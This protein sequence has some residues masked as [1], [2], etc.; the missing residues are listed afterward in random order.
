MS[1]RRR[2]PTGLPTKLRCERGLEPH[3]NRPDPSR[4]DLLVCIMCGRKCVRAGEVQPNG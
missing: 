3:A 2:V 1:G 4:P